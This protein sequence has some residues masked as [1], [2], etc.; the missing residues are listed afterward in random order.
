MPRIFFGNFE[1]EHELAR[2]QSGDL[3]RTA[4]GELLAAGAGSLSDRAWVW[5]AIAEPGDVVVINGE[6]PA[7]EF[8]P[9]AELGL[10]IPQFCG[11]AERLPR[12]S[13]WEL[14]PWGWTESLLRRAKEHG[15]TAAAPPADV[16]CRV[17]SREFR[18][19]LER[20][21]NIGLEQAAIARSLNDLDAVVAS[22]GENPRGWLLKANYGMSGREA[23]R[24]RGRNL[25]GNIHNWA[26]KRLASNGPI[27]FEPIVERIAEA[28]IQL[29]I[30]SNGAPRLMGV[31]PLLVDT[32]G[33][34]RGS[35]FGCLPEEIACWQPAVDVALR[36]ALELQRLGYFG[37][38]GID[39]MLYRDAAGE[40]R[41]RPLQDLNARWTMGRLALGFCRLLGGGGAS[42]DG[43]AGTAESEYIV[44][45]PPLT[46]LYEGGDASGE[47]NQWCG[48]WLHFSGLRL[49]KLSVAEWLHALERHLPGGAIA[50][51]ASPRSARSNSPC[52][53]LV[54]APSPQVRNIAEA[55]LFNHL[56]PQAIRL[57]TEY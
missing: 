45:S 26:V 6:M 3:P 43:R 48:S 33:V 2:G 37:P 25:E 34:Y 49:G 32:S 1:F 14:V 12:G 4:P 52:G 24:G 53:V 16:V 56:T 50:V 27:I 47:T 17:N 29:E 36:A 35:R 51:P 11:A 31:T 44:T 40:V 57:S 55:T 15:W 19:G 9:L 22:S 54:L 5:T 46:P 13:D 38:L 10:S 18:F 30:P 20:D 23:M 41:L 39:A 8:S 42:R 7:A 28:G 21:W